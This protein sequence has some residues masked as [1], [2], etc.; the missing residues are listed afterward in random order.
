MSAELVRGLWFHRL[1]QGKRKAP[2][3]FTPGA[4]PE[5]LHRG[6]SI[7]A[8]LCNKPSS[9]AQKISENQAPNPLG[10]ALAVA[11]PLTS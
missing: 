4:W 3:A 9:C 7:V 5:H 6:P 2:N 1:L 10:C 8:Q 11:G